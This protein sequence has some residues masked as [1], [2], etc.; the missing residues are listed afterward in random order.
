MTKAVQP[1]KQGRGV[2]PIYLDEDDQPQHSNGIYVR[3]RRAE[4]R[5]E[6]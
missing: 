4:T 2:S 3:D 5:R 6:G 1:V